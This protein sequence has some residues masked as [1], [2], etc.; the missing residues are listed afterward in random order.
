MSESLVMVDSSKAEDSRNSQEMWRF[1]GDKPITLTELLESSPEAQQ[2]K[3]FNFD[4]GSDRRWGQSF[5]AT[6]NNRRKASLPTLPVTLNFPSSSSSVNLESSK[7]SL[8]NSSGPIE[9][10]ETVGKKRMRKLR[11]DERE[12]TK[13]PEWFNLPAAEMNQDRRNDLDALQFRAALDTKR[14]YKRNSLPSRPK[15][16]QV[17]RIVDNPADFFHSRVPRKQRKKTIAEEMV[18]EVSSTVS[19]L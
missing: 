10:S 19:H 1:L 15:Y 11:K 14:F 16:F 5:S 12:K 9:P 17:G 13:G 3:K 4:C 2:L 6:N 18:A 7:L 8:L